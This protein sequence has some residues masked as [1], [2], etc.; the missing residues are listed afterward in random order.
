MAGASIGAY[1][2]NTMA[3]AMLGKALG[4]VGEATIDSIEPT[5][6]GGKFNPRAGARAGAKSIYEDARKVAVEA[7]DEQLDKL[8]PEYRKIYEKAL[9]GEYPDSASAIR[10]VDVSE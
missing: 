7:L 5:K 10:D 8:P 1:M 4:E 2:G 6:A 3:G 9:A